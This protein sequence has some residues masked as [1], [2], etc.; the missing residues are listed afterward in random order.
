MRSQTPGLPTDRPDDPADAELV[1]RFQA[2]G[3]IRCIENLWRKYARDVFRRCQRFLRN[4]AAAEDVTVDVFVKVMSNLRAQY[5][6][7]HF[8]G[9]LFTIA[10]HEC[11]NYR[12]RAAERLRVGDTD[13]LVLAASDDP[14]L[15]IDVSS[16]IGQLSPPQRIAIKQFFAHGYSYTEIAE[17]EGWSLKDVKSHVQNGRRVFKKLWA[18]RPQRKAT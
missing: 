15:A 8:K 12:Q 3:E 17:L 7:D 11:V 4:A 9:W 10:K 18:A 13:D 16:V 14:A 1:E 2:T 6:P 5:R